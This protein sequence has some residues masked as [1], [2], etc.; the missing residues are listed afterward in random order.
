[1]EL[2]RL[3]LIVA[4]LSFHSLQGYVIN[5]FDRFGK[6]GYLD[7]NDDLLTSSRLKQK[8]LTPLKAD[9]V[10]IGTQE[11][12]TIGLAAI[13][14]FGL[15]KVSFLKKKGQEEEE[16]TSFFAEKWRKPYKEKLQTM[17]KFARKQRELRGLKYLE[18]EVKN[19]NEMVISKIAEFER[20]RAADSDE[21][22]FDDFDYDDDDLEEDDEPSNN[23]VEISA[24]SLPST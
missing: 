9:L 5:K 20:G 21:D 15:P 14:L 2:W 1:M 13:A 6:T 17:S 8:L 23:K 11:A 3:C 12:I 4:F 19:G 16:S 10:N 7:R 24:K 18:E 22:I